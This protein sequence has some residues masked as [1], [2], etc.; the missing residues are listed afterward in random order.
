VPSCSSGQEH[1]T[2][3][4]NTSQKLQILKKLTVIF[5]VQTTT[6][7]HRIT[8]RG[9]SKHPDVLYQ[10]HQTA[11]QHLE[12]LQV[13]WST[14]HHHHVQH[15]QVE[16]QSALQPEVHNLAVTHYINTENSST[17]HITLKHCYSVHTVFCTCFKHSY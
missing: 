5:Y 10:L 11:Q 17:V 13:A 6:L 2:A 1:L 3:H 9:Q 4:S 16:L 15:N 14:D 12:T 7:P 8:A